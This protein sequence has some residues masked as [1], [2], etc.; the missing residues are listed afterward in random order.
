[1]KLKK[2]VTKTVYAINNNAKLRAP[3]DERN[4]KKS[5]KSNV[6][7]K[8]LKGTVTVGASYAPYVEW[9]TGIYAKKQSLA[10]KVP[11]SYKDEDGEWHRT[12]GQRAQPFWSPSID[13]GEQVFNKHFK[14]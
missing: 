1:M 10:K 3:V 11:W 12:R 6:H 2:G 9:G 5:I 8:G 13:K 14:K 7:A 4:L